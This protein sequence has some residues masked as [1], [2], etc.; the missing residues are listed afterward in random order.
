MFYCSLADGRVPVVDQS[1][2]EMVQTD[3]PESNLVVVQSVLESILE[4]VQ[5]GFPESNL[6]VAQNVHQSILKMV[7]SG[8]SKSNRE[9]VQDDLFSNLAVV[10][11]VSQA[12]LEIDHSNSS[13]FNL[14]MARNNHVPSGK[15]TPEVAGGAVATYNRYIFIINIRKYF[16]W[17]E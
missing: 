2:Q 3:L 5:G 12:I 16:I 11:S 13:E 6:E 8:P 17:K 4:I 10:Q 1:N 14:E 9:V 15:S 7:Q